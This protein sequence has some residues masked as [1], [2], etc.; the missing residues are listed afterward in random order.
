MES[1]E[2]CYVVGGIHRCVKS[3]SSLLCLCSV[4]W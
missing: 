4:E 3:E 1:V 2:L